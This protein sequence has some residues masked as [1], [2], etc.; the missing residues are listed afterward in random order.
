MKAFTFHLTA[1]CLPLVLPVGVLIFTPKHAGAQ[2]AEAWVQRYNGPG[3]GSDQPTAIATDGS[4]NVFVTGYSMG[5][6]WDHATIKYSASGSR[7]G[8]I[9]TMV[10]LA[11]M[12]RHSTWRWIQMV[13]R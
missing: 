2:V 9:A 5:V 6:A 12:T 7:Y 3:N 4:G 10:L 11:V 1:I 13:T 8:P